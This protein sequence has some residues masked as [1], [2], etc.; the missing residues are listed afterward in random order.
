MLAKIMLA[1][2][3]LA[4]PLVAQTKPDATVSLD[5]SQ[6]LA[7]YDHKPIAIPDGDAK[8]V[9]HQVTLF[10]VA[11]ASLESPIPSLDGQQPDPVA[12]AK[13]DHLAA[14]LFDHRTAA[15][16]SL[17]ERNLILERA[18]II[19]PAVILGPVWKI[20]DPE[21]YAKQVEGK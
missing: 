6:V 1:L 18:K 13:R 21:G 7:G 10:D 17:A 14:Y 2:F 3:A 19:E 12:K 8:G 5:F 4:A 9:P 16:L 15:V 11:V 20:L